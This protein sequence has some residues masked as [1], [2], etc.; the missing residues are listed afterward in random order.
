MLVVRCLSFVV[1]CRLPRAVVRCCFVFERC[2]VSRVLWC[3]V[4]VC[5]VLLDALLLFVAGR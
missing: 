5:L 2:G 4:I 1:C 3:V